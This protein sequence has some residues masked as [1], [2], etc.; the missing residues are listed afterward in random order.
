MGRSRTP[1][2][3]YFFGFLIRTRK[4]ISSP[5]RR[6]DVT[7]APS[8]AVLTVLATSRAVKPTWARIEKFS[9]SSSSS[10][11]GRLLDSI[12]KTPCIFVRNDFAFSSNFRRIISSLEIKIIWTGFIDTFREFEKGEGHYTWWSYMRRAREKNVGWRIDY[13]IISPA[14]KSSL[15]NSYIL[16]DV[17]GSDHCPI[18]LDINI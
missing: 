4:S 9:F 13:F 8:K 10:F 7:R 12:A 18:V 17:M 3:L 14:L 11:P 5:S 15:K 6:I 16:L 2:A 1:S